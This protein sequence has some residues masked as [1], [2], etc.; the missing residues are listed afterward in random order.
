MLNSAAVDIFCKR[1]S[2]F[3]CEQSGKIIGV[4]DK[5]DR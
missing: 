2:Q 1:D 5:A 4:E 3:F